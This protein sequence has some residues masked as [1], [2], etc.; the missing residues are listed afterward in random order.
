MLNKWILAT[1]LLPLIILLAGCSQFTDVDWDYIIP[2]GYQ[3]IL[4]IR[5]ECPGGNPLNIQN[6]KIRLEFNDD[7]TACIKDKFLQTSGKMFIHN[8]AG[9]SVSL[10]DLAQNENDYVFLD[11][12]VE[13][14]QVY[15]VD[16]GT[17][18]PFWVGTKKDATFKGLYDFLENR[19][20]IP[21]VKL[22]DIPTPP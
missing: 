6:G 15:G 3:G 10:F 1:L 2:N 18:E 22:T 12:G 11:G 13:G 20:G 7:G 19:F 17:F 21:Q 5:Y 9:Q 8:K 4:V 16:Y 14:L